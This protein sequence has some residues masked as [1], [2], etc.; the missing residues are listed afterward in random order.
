M[1]IILYRD[2]LGFFVF[3]FYIWKRCYEV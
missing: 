2:G 1:F 3:V